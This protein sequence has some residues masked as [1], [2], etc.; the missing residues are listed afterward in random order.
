M[1]RSHLQL[2]DCGRKPE[3]TNA[4]T[5]TKAP[6]RRWTQTQDLLLFNYCTKLQQ[7]SPL[8]WT[9]PE[10]LPPTGSGYEHTV[11]TPESLNFCAFLSFML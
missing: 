11:T 5:G 3:T 9:D 6:G 2:Q 1:G 7:Q 10:T 8:Y 4:N